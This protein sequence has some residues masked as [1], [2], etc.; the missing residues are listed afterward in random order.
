MD[1]L[2]NQLKSIKYS[3]PVLNVQTNYNNY[4]QNLLKDCDNNYKNLKVNQYLFNQMEELTFKKISIYQYL[5]KPPLIKW[6]G[7]KSDEINEFIQYIP[8]DSKLYIEP[9]IGGG[10]V[11]FYLSPKKAVISDVHPELINFYKSIKDGY[12]LD[13][14]DFMAN[15]PNNEDTY[16]DI[17]SM[18][19]NDYIEDACRFYY[20]RKT[21]FRG[22][23]RYNSSGEFNI[24]Y[25]KYKTI[26]YDNLLDPEYFDL[27]QNT[28]IYKCDY[29]EIFNK[30]NSPDNFVFLDP[31]YDSKFTDYGYCKFARQQQEELANVFKTTNNKCL[32]I[33]GDTPLIRE[34]YNGYIAGS[35]GKN[36]RFKLYSNRVGNE[37]NT[38]HLII[39]NY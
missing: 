2:I 15:N 22:M 17:R 3:S 29:K 14:Y 4:L 16:Y 19:V 23:M 30:Y 11:Y 36:Y 6:S 26:N 34:L 28:E 24:P 10:S 18:K 21:C 13:I 38:N 20:L 1:K 25:G 32:M 37:I 9:F 27:L 8:K 33:I 35:Y 7:G 31:P 5:K 12:N 39:K